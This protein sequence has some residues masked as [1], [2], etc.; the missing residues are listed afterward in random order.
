MS[1]L[2]VE[3]TSQFSYGCFLYI[4]VIFCLYYLNPFVCILVWFRY[5][6]NLSFMMA[7]SDDQEQIE[8]NTSGMNFGFSLG[9]IKYVYPLYRS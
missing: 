9:N 3:N 4:F 6:A 2:L 5:F 1:E 7:D 8:A